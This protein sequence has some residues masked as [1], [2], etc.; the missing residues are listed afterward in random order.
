MRHLPQNMSR[1]IKK[2]INTPRPTSNKT[3]ITKEINEKNIEFILLEKNLL[4]K[5]RKNEISNK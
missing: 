1:Q 3:S 5:N 4:T 2:P